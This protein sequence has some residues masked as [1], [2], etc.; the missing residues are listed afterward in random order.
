M[1][2]TAEPGTPVE[3]RRATGAAAS[4]VL[5]DRSVVLLR[6]LDAPD[7]RVPTQRRRADSRSPPTGCS[8]SPGSAST[9]PRP[10]ADYLADLGVTHLYLLAVPAGGAG[11]HPRLRRRRPPRRQRRARRR[12]RPRPA[13]ATRSARPGSGQVL[14]IVPNHMA[15]T[16]PE[17]RWW[18][19]VLENGPSSRVRR[20][21]STSTGTRPRRSCATPC[22]CRSSATTT[23]GCSS[24]GELTLDRDGGELHDPLLRP[25]AAG[26][27][28]GR[29]TPLLAA[30]AAARPASDDLAFVA[31]AFGRLPPATAHRPARACVE[32]HRDKEVLRRQLGRLLDDERP[33]RRPTPIDA[34]VG[35]RQRRRRRPRRAAR[36]PELPPRLLAHGRAASSTTAASSTSTRSS[37][38][39]SRTSRSSTTPT[40]WCSRWVRDGRGRRAAGRPPRRAARPRAATSSAW[41]EATGG[42]VGRRR[43]DPR[44]G[45]G[46]ARRRGR[47]P[48]RPATTSSTAVG[49]LFVDPAGEEPL[50]RGS[51]ARSPARR[52]TGTTWSTRPSDLVL[53]EVLAA[54]VNR[55][56]RPARRGVRAPPPLPRL[57]PP[58]AARGAARGCS[59]ASPSTAPTCGPRR[60]LGAADRRRVR[61]PRPWRGARERRPDLDPELFDFLARPAAAA[62]ARAT[63]SRHELRHA[64]PAADRPGHGQ[65]RRGHRLLPLQPAASRS[66]RSAATPAASA[67]PVDEFHAANAA[68]RRPRW[69]ATMLRHVDPRH[70][71]QRGRAGPA[72]PAVGDPRGVGATPCE[73]W[74]D[75]VDA[76]H[77]PRRL[78]RPP[79]PSTSCTRRWSA[80]GRST[81]SGPWPTWRR[82][83]KEA[84][85][86]TS[87]IEPDADYDDG[88][89]RV[90]RG[91]A[92]RRRRS[93][94]SS[95]PSS[96]RWS[97]PGRVNVAGPEAAEADRARRARHLPGHRA[98]GPEPR[99]PR[100][101]P[102]GRLR[103]CAARLLAELHGLRAGGACWPG[104]TRALPKLLADPPGA[105]PAAAPPGAVRPGGVVRAAGGRRR[106]GRPRRRA[107]LRGGRRGRGRAPPGAAASRRR[108]LGRHRPSSCRPGPV[109]RR[110]STGD[111]RRRAA[112]RA[113]GRPARPASRWPLL[114]RDGV[115]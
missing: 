53:R 40:S 97:Q 90:R 30:A 38:C 37:G 100:Q 77:W 41:R 23:A 79:T 19:D 34:V 70:Q 102:A 42:R 81:S 88:A 58:R 56:D 65:G 36:A 111:E 109:A 20:P 72:G 89:A 2:D 39:A 35:R 45:R 9:R 78:A 74:T 44:A 101:P 64:V 84:K 1:L 99:R 94:P 92:R 47:S 31:D 11:Q 48:A 21:T 29:S 52:P 62:G 93:P 33:T 28:R 32:R 86:H 91:R 5:T 106:A 113:G 82:R 104:P 63:R 25:R 67:S 69:P 73:R 71:A 75:G 49:G 95:T 51:T 60:A 12:R 85:V 76:R 66:T 80:P 112:A 115:T 61:R 8:C 18:W 4:V 10:V 107:S 54:D 96:R 16:G 15:I 46:A 26:G 14:D 110:R 59:P 27:A 7:A 22:S 57:H 24:A 98:V 6:R 3:R 108:R 17:N 83:R 87:W 50:D 43:E 114:E 105:A 55:L 103:R 68:G 13:C